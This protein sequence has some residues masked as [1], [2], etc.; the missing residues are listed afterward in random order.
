MKTIKKILTI[1][2]VTMIVVGLNQAV[3]AAGTWNGTS[4]NGVTL[5]CNG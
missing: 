5:R 4:L 2:A 3:Y 1:A